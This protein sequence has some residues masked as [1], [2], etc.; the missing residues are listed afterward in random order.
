MGSSQAVPPQDLAR[1]LGIQDDSDEFLEGNKGEAERI[2]SSTSFLS[3]LP[4]LIV[5]SSSSPSPSFWN[6]NRPKSSSISPSKKSKFSGFVL[7]SLS[8]PS[9]QK[10]RAHPFL[11]LPLPP[12]VS[13]R[14]SPSPPSTSPNS[15]SSSKKALTTLSTSRT[16]P[17]SECSLLPSSNLISKNSFESNLRRE[18][19]SSGGRCLCWGV[20]RWR[21]LR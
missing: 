20:I 14:S 21:L 19:C 8:F 7:V 6:F 13:H 5:P 16:S 4:L 18:L 10:S 1:A 17:S 3:F 11:P 12:L 15:S 2:V 9:T